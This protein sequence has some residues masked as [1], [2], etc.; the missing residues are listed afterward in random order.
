MSRNAQVGDHFKIN[1]P[2]PGTNTGEGYDWVTIEAIEDDTNAEAETESVL[3]RV[4]P[5]ENP[6]NEK[7]DVA[8]FF[9][10]D[11]SSS[12]TVHRQGNKV[13]AGVHGRNEV[14]NTGAESLLDKARN[15]AVAVGA[16][17][18]LSTPQWKSLSKGLLGK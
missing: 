9:T 5:A 1:I 10:D 6:T 11:A 2:G 16:I 14:P 13:T 3:V 8:H 18:G 12:F 17:I 7:K 15:A 4:R